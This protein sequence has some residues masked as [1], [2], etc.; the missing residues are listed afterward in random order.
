MLLWYIS[1][2]LLVQGSV[3]VGR[4]ALMMGQ[5]CPLDWLPERVCAAMSRI[6]L[7]SVRLYGPLLQ[8]A[9]QAYR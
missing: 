7:E 1:E 5:H 6:E 4:L 9:H 8:L 2:H 3:I